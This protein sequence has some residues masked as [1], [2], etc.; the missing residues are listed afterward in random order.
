MG[1]DGRRREEGIGGGDG[2]EIVEEKGNGMGLIIDGMGMEIVR[3]NGE[4]K[5]EALL[6]LGFSWGGEG[7]RGGGNTTPQYL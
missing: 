5:G 2:I 6:R 7:G 4:R 1:W 3:G